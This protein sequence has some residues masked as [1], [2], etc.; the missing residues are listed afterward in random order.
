MI[1]ELA[2]QSI[3]NKLRLGSGTMLGN[4][5]FYYAAG[6]ICGYLQLELR[7]DLEPQELYRQ[8]ESQ[9][10][11]KEIENPAAAHLA[12]MIRYY[13]VEDHHDR[14]MEQLFEMGRRDGVKS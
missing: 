5:E 13:K 12:K 2:V 14:Q 11:G 3:Q 7:G 4:Y 6:I 10:E 1:L 8:L 9:T